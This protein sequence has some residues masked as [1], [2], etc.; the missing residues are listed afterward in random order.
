MHLGSHVIFEEPAIAMAP[1][2]DLSTQ[3]GAAGESYLFVNDVL[4]LLL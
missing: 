1:Q 2:D 3:K 4:Q